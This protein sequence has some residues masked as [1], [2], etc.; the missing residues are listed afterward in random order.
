MMSRERRKSDAATAHPQAL[1]HIGAGIAFFFGIT[2]IRTASRD[3]AAKYQPRNFRFFWF[4]SQMLRNP[5]NKTEGQ[6][7]L[8]I[9]QMNVMSEIL[10]V[11]DKN[12]KWK[13]MGNTTA[14]NPATSRDRPLAESPAET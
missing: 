14:M 1:G 7:I 4:P 5:R 10:T 6:I 8:W 3:P 12:T 2:I 11:L 13:T 9:T